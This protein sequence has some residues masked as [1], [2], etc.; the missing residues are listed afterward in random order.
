MI[1]NKYFNLV[2]N[3]DLHWYTA[4]FAP[5]IKYS[6]KHITVLRQCME[7]I[8]ETGMILWLWLEMKNKP[9]M[10]STL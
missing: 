10:H 5:H 6:N 4:T 8:I 3:F 1:L 7:K 2:T 9:N